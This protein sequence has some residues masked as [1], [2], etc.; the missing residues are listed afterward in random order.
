MTKNLF[1]LV[2]IAVGLSSCSNKV[3][4]SP[5]AIQKYIKGKWHDE[6][7]DQGGLIT[8]YRFEM[9]ET[10]IR[11]WKSSLILS[12]T[13][14]SSDN[15]KNDWEEQAPVPVSIGSIQTDS[16]SNQFR[17]LGTCSYG[18]FWFEKSHH[19]GDN[20]LYFKDSNFS[21]DDYQSGNLERG[22]EY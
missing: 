17:D 19:D 8:Y 20:R 9:T 13:G 7:V 2:F 22:W 11:C 12:N 21:E 1:F 16:Y 6:R 5:E 3:I 10:E 18:R 15:E 14:R 4:E